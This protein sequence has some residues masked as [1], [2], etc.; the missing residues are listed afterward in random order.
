MTT[1]P[2]RPRRSS[3]RTAATVVAFPST[4]A[5][6]VLAACIQA[7]V[8][9]IIWGNPGEAKTATI[10][11]LGRAWH[12]EVTTIIVS[13][14]DATDFSG[15]P[16]ESEG[17]QSHL[18]IGWALDANT[19]TTRG[20]DGS[21]V[22]LDEFSTAEP[23]VRKAALRILQERVVGEVALEPHV[24]MVAAA[25]PPDQAVD[26]WDLAAPEANRFIHV[27]WQFDA[28]QWK[29]GLASGF[30]DVPAPS[31]TD[32][33]GAVDDDADADVAARRARAVALVRGFVTANPKH[34]T[35]G[36]PDNPA[37]ASGAWPSPRS[38]HNLV[39]V[40]AHLHPRDDAARLGAMK[41]AVGEGPA[42]ELASYAEAADL[43][44]PAQVLADPS[45]VDW[46]GERPDRLFVTLDAVATLA[47]TTGTASAWERAM[48]VM[49]A[50]ALA[51]IPD[52]ALPSVRTLLETK[53]PGAAVPPSM[54]DAFEPLFQASGA[55]A[56]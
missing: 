42:R 19:A 18:P 14:R 38:W 56:A 1:T 9:V 26:G 29:A 28:E 35:P 48:N 47:V 50:P 31:L 12:H 40:L 44:D 13:T 3:A 36:V 4:S 41:G 22:F 32:L 52:V 43:Y 21:I 46:K 55:W 53:P 37:L 45:I 17:R 15:L 23:R 54:A 39:E 34:L 24:A 27:D 2:K 51:G 5:V 6:R 16:T 49:N 20:F 25:N 10:T 33:L 11:A 7:K 8:P 30:Q